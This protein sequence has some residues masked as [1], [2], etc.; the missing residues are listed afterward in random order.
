MLFPN[1][2]SHFQLFC[3]ANFSF[4]IFKRD[5]RK[6]DSLVVTWFNL[7]FFT[8]HFV[9]FENHI[10]AAAESYFFANVPK[11]K[12]PKGEKR[13]SRLLFQFQRR[14]YK[15]YW[16][17]TILNDFTLISKCSTKGA[18]VMILEKDRNERETG[19]KKLNLSH[20]SQ[21]VFIRIIGEKMWINFLASIFSFSIFLF[22]FSWK[23]SKKK[24]KIV[25]KKW[26]ARKNG[27]FVTVLQL[28]NAFYCVFVSYFG[29]ALR[30]VFVVIHGRH[31][32]DKWNETLAYNMWWE[33]ACA[34]ANDRERIFLILD[35]CACACLSHRRS[36]CKTRRPNMVSDCCRLIQ[37]SFWHSCTQSTA[38]FIVSISFI[39]VFL[40]AFFVFCIFGFFSSTHFFFP[41]HLLHNFSLSSSSSSQISSYFISFH[42][43]RFVFFT[44]FN[45][46]N[47][48][49]AQIATYAIVK[50][51]V[52]CIFPLS[53]RIH[54]NK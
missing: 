37:C 14:T 7:W 6:W 54:S 3:S 13:Y 38:V 49:N 10:F 31:S 22:Q 17:A 21:E 32:T 24:K 20:K 4:S 26:I 5:C 33:C 25:T 34:Y 1:S 11:K 50:C 51:N 43:Y 30:Q 35:A 28:H 8:V 42:C 36:N 40:L 27:K 53:E 41:C 18:A 23:I 2:R 16:L 39:S 45:R 12:L 15:I 48:K 44:L 47:L 19:K 52:K 46:T 9:S 29:L